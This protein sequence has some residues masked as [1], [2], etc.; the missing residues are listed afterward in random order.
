MDATS[1]AVN[2]SVLVRR[3]T[4]HS[5]AWPRPVRVDILAEMVRKIRSAAEYARWFA[6]LGGKARTR[7]LSAEERSAAASKA[8]RAKWSKLT[9]AQRHAQARKAAAAR[10]AQKGP[11]A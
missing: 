1:K 2:A 5:M 9:P 7:S 4:L 3:Y 8:S 11:S 6:S 10:W